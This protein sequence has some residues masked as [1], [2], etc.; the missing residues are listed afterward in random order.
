[1]LYRGIVDDRDSQPVV[2]SPVYRQVFSL[3]TGQRVDEQ[4][5]EVTVYQVRIVE[6][7]LQVELP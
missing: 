7:R 2:G 4:G 1:M 5:Q 3:V 6:G